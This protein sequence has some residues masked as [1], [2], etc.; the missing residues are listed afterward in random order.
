MNARM[1]LRSGIAVIAVAAAMAIGPSATAAPA[2]VIH[3]HQV[4]ETFVDTITCSGEP[5]AEITVTYNSVEKT[6]TTPD[7]G[8]HATFTESGT[9]VAVPLDG[10]QSATGHFAVWGGFNDNGT[11]VNGT[12]TLNIRGTYADGTPVSLHLVDHFNTTPGGA[13]FFFTN[14][15]D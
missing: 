13:E 9:F 2:E 7:G 1:M 15:R 10:S 11:T 14:C 6:S 3:E 4:A 12:F 5:N 8:I